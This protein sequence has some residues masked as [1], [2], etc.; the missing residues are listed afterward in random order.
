MSSTNINPSALLD[1]SSKIEQ[2]LE[3]RIDINSFQNSIKKKTVGSQRHILRIPT[4]VKT[5][6]K[7]TKRFYT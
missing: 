1:P 7:I 3:K 4:F 6:I 2:R 5:A